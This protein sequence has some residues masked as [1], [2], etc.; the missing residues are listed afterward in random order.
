MDKSLKGM[1][2]KTP[3]LTKPGPRPKSLKIEGNWRMAIT[4]ALKKK[5]AFEGWHKPSK[6]T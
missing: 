4:K 6:N 2:T 1:R 5:R 3:K